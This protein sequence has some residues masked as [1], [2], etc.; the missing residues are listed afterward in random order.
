MFLGNCFNRPASSLTQLNSLSLTHRLA[1]I[2]IKTLT[3]RK[4]RR[5]KHYFAL[6]TRNGAESFLT[7]W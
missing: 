4:S 7:N 3:S 5:V 1:G 6:M 2:R